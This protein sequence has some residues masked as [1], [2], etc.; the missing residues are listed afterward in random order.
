MRRVLEYVDLILFDIKHM[1]SGS[2]REKCGV[3]NELILENL[4]KTAKMCTVWL[5]VPLIPNYN[6]SETNL[7]LI[8][9]LASRTAVDRVSLLPYHEYG[10][11][12]YVRLGREYS[13]N[14]AAI[15]KPDDETVTKS[16]GLLESYG[17]EVSVGS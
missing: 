11:Q 3:S 14:E 9:E 15:L 10:K 12:K 17:L 16:K 13:F 7:R 8:A 4:E 1:N 6:D 2:C 5:R